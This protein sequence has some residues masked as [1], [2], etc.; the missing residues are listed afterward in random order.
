MPFVLKNARATYQRMITKIFELILG[1]I[2]DTY[3]D[4][5]VVKSKEKPDHIRDMTEVFTILKRHKVRL[6]MAKCAFGVS[7]RKFMGH[8]VT[9]QGIEVNLEQITAINNL[10]IPRNTK[11]VQKLTGM[12][13]TLNRFISKSSN[14]FRTFFKLLR[15]NTK[16]LWNE[17][18]GLALPKFKK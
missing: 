18:C 13:T 12:A 14:K 17:K 2:M 7:S 9:R 3:I 16:F 8:L 15:K 5:M 10:I 1:K 6:N 11:E 4:D